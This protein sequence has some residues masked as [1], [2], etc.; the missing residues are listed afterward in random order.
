LTRLCV[1][2]HGDSEGPRLVPAPDDLEVPTDEPFVARAV[3][4][5]ESR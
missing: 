4:V 5:H 2:R 3:T 1:G